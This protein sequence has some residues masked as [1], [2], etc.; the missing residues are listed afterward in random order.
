MAKESHGRSAREV[1][2]AYCQGTPLRTEIE[3]RDATLLGD[4][5]VDAVRAL[6]ERFGKTNHAAKSRR[7]W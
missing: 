3:E 6:T 2:I 4:A 7:M 1:G 5:T